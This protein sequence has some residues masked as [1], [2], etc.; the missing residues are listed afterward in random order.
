MPTAWRLPV[1]NRFMQCIRVVLVVSN[2]LQVKHDPIPLGVETG[3]IECSLSL[4]PGLSL[5][6]SYKPKKVN[7]VYTLGDATF[8]LV[9]RCKTA[10]R[11]VAL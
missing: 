3:T 11:E 2:H 6:H 7:V 10:T 5:V 8:G 1:V 9:C 4:F